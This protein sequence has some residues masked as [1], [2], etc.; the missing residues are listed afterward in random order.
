MT[1]HMT[2]ISPRCFEPRITEG[3]PDT[4][5][6]MIRNQNRAMTNQIQRAPGL[7][8]VI[9]NCGD[10]D[11]MGADLYHSKISLNH[12]FIYVNGLILGHG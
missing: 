9:E 1:S 4:Q 7:R 10:K 3:R 5:V 11:R 12:L 6:G 2:S 8:L